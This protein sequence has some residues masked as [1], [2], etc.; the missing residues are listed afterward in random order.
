MTSAALFVGMINCST[1]ITNIPNA[2]N[3]VRINGFNIMIIRFFK[4]Y[5]SPY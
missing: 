1:K 5:L 4:F 3:A 2:K